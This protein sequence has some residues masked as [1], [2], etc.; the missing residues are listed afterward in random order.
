MFIFVIQ[1]WSSEFSLTDQFMNILPFSFF[2]VLIFWLKIFQVL[3]EVWVIPI[4]LVSY[5][6]FTVNLADGTIRS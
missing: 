1:I 5:G 4:I 2:C 3:N 6:F